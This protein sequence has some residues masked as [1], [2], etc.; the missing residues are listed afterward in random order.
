MAFINDIRTNNIIQTSQPMNLA[1]LHSDVTTL[2]AYVP[3]IQ[4]NNVI[5]GTKQFNLLNLDNQVI[6]HDG[7]IQYSGLRRQN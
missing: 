4:T 6:Q 1:T 7:T 5:Q 2:L 3:E